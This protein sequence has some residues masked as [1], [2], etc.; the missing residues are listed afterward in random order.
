[1]SSHNNF[2]LRLTESQQRF[3]VLWEKRLEGEL[4]LKE[5]AEMDEIIFGLSIKKG[6]SKT[7]SLFKRTRH[8]IFTTTKCSDE[9]MPL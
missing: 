2:I 9:L 8:F 6:H 3:E 1:M 7:E 5:L 4:P